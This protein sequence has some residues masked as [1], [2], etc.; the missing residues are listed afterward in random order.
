MGLLVTEKGGSHSTDHDVNSHSDRDQETGRDRTHP[1]EVSD[2][3]GTTQDKHGRD[4][5]VRSQP[6]KNPSVEN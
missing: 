2:S 3:C 4:D 5:D 6:K 1:G